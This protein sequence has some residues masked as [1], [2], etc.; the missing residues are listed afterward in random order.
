MFLCDKGLSFHFAFVFTTCCLLGRK[1]R[2]CCHLPYRLCY[3]CRSHRLWGERG[4]VAKEYTDNSHSKL[5]FRLCTFLRRP[6]VQAWVHGETFLAF[7]TLDAHCCAHPRFVT[8]FLKGHKMK[9]VSSLIPFFLA[10]VLPLFIFSAAASDV[11]SGWEGGGSL[12]AHCF[13]SLVHG[14]TLFLWNEGL[15]DCTVPWS[16][17]FPPRRNTWEGVLAS[18]WFCVLWTMQGRKRQFECPLLLPDGIV[19]FVTISGI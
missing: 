14:E 7:L 6:A 13:L 11:Q 10:G 5:C 1:L 3:F 19:G 17:T 8:S 12:F 18:L 4:K 2:H 16:R 15:G 9:S